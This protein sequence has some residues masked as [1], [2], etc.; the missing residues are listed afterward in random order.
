MTVTREAL[1]YPPPVPFTPDDERFQREAIA[2]AK[3][4]FSEREVPVGAVVVADGHMIGRGRNRREALGD[5]THHAEIE[6]IRE[7]AQAAGTWRLDGAT[8]YAT[9]EPCRRSTP[10]SPASSSVARTPKPDTAERWPTCRRT[11]D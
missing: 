6:A 2:F 3:I 9:V 8:L 5:P 11:R 10:G 1:R 4:A 7:A